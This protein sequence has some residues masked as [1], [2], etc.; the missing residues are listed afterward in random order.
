MK[1]QF[2]TTS[3]EEVDL[4][5]LFKKVGDFF[6]SMVKRLFLVISFYKKYKIV[7]IV[8]IVAGVVLGYFLDD[9]AK[10][11]YPYENRVIVI[12]NFESVDYLYETVDEI[13]AKI[14]YRDS[15]YFQSFLAEDYKSLKLVEIEPIPDIYNFITESK[16]NIEVLK[17]LFQNQEFSEFIEDLPTSKN[18]KYHKLNF[19]IEGKNSKVIIDK[20]LAQINKNEHFLQYKEVYQNST[21]TQIK[22]TNLM[23]AQADSIIKSGSRLAGKSGSNQ[24]VV[25]SDGRLD[26][27]L[28]R[29]QELLDNQLILTKKLTDQTEVVKLVSANY[30]VVNKGLLSFSNKVKM[31]LL[32]VL[33]FSFFFFIRFSYRS[34]KSIAKGA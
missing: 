22:E 6:R 4:G 13:N 19:T 20:I 31:P 25:I 33:L 26:M 24:S 7:T 17:I 30:N 11:S 21:R 32:F 8:L 29:K 9:R 15:L 12:P 10:D 2:N 27:I 18:Y 16:E 34:L 28:F 14:K 23:L 3:T 5:Y 1:D